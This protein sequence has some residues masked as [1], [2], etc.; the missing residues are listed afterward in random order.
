LAI[1]HCLLS[2]GDRAVMD[3][4]Q[5][6][7]AVPSYSDGLAPDLHRLPSLLRT[8]SNPVREKHTSQLIQVVPD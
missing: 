7:E 2:I 4:W 3:Q 8:D 1:G 6:V 5:F